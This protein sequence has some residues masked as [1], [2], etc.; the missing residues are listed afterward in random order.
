MKRF[1]IG[2]IGYGGMGSYHHK[3]IP[4]PCGLRFISA[5]DIN[6]KRLEKAKESGLTAYENLD[7]FLSDPRLDV[8]LIATPNSS[9]KKLAIRAMNAHKHVICEKPV[10]L[11]CN[12]FEEMLKA[13]KNNGVLFTVHQNRRMDEDFRIIKKLYDE[14]GLGEVFRIE[15]RAQGSRGI[16]NTWR[17]KKEYGGGMLYDW[18]VHL[19]DRVLWMIDS[20]VTSVYA[21][22]QHV[23]HTEVDDNFRLTLTFKNGISA[24]I[25]IGTCNYIMHPIWYVAGKNATAQ[26][27]Y[28]NLTGKILRLIDND[29]KFEDE[30]KPSVAGPSITL[31][32]RA[33]D[34]VEEL[35]LPK[36]K[37]DQGFFYKNFYNALCGKAPLIVKPNE[38]RRTMQIIDLAFRSGEKNQVIKCEI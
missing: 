23:N 28:W 27:D 7:V 37:T 36:V 34:T 10:A 18:G 25:E 9:H 1:N 29:I 26:I 4:L 32:P 17:R 13:S 12:E 31:A 21:E 35:P 2:I 15:S 38:V 11:N 16:A 22:F 30:I 24:L 5:Y 8:V 3:S 14:N 20:P 19:I 6:P 33:A